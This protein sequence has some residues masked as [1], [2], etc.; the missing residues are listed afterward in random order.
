MSRISNKEYFLGEGDAK[1][2]IRNS[3]RQQ[4]QFGIVEDTPML[5]EAQLFNKIGND[6]RLWRFKAR[7]I[8]EGEIKKMEE[9][10]TSYLENKV[11][12]LKEL[13][14]FAISMIPKES[15]PEGVHEGSILPWMKNRVHE[16]RAN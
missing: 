16:K 4:F 6:A 7:R 9:K 10:Q 8:S 3:K 14:D 12:F 15:Y 13:V 11:Q 2:G 5:A 1:Y